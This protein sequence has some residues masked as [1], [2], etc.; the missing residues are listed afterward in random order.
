M[1]PKSFVVVV[2]DKL[3]TH[4]FASLQLGLLVVLSVATGGSYGKAVAADQQTAESQASGQAVAQQ[5]IGHGLGLGLGLDVGISE[6]EIHE[7]HIHEH[8]E[9]HE[10]HDPGYWKKKV[11]WKEGWKK[12][13]NPAK[14]QIWNPSWKK[15]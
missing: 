11:T 6:H 2:V 14:K 9:H 5:R 1:L 7:H 13:W 4:T 8:H 12:I 15:V 3:L 10:H